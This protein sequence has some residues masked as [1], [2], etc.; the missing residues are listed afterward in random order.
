MCSGMPVMDYHSLN[1]TGAEA[2]SVWQG[3]FGKSPLLLSV[4][5]HP[6]SAD[7]GGIFDDFSMYLSACGTTCE[8]QTTLL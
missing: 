8:T 3:G 5:Y 7:A 1:L 4:V 6:T 2:I